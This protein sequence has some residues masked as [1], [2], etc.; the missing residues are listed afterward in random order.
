MTYPL[1]GRLRFYDSTDPMALPTAELVALYGYGPYAVS[2]EELARFRG[3][4]LISDVPAAPAAARLCRVLDVERG[5]ARP[6]DAPAFAQARLDY[7]HRGDVTFYQSLSVVPDVV[8][9]MSTTLLSYRLWVAWWDRPEVPTPAEIV[10]EL[11]AKYDCHIPERLIWAVQFANNEA[12]DIDSSEL[13]GKDDF[14]R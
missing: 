1:N 3:H 12:A 4:I 6:A 7:G 8:K 2:T 11:A 10:Q 9:A 14:V 13:F 5:A